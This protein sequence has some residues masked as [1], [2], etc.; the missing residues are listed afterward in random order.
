MSGGAVRT[1]F[2]PGR[3]AS[4]AWV[5]APEATFVAALAA[6][7]ASIRLYSLAP[8]PALLP[9]R[10][11][12]APEPHLLHSLPAPSSDAAPALV[13][14]L[15]IDGA[16][17]IASAAPDGVVALYSAADRRTLR[18]VAAVKAHPCAATALAVS[19]SQ[20]VSAAADGCVH[21]RALPALNSAP[22]AAYREPGG[23]V[24]ALAWVSPHLIASCGAGASVCV[25]DVRAQLTAQ[26]LTEYAAP[27]RARRH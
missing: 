18:P 3:C 22:L 9:D 16:P 7:I 6:P 8:R 11:P 13:R 19:P 12:P 26:R 25:L 17:H 2:V 24:T 1:W 14:A 10:A 20:L 15:S 27:R 23:S 21:L 4:V 5:S